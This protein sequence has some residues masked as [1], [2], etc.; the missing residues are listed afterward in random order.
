MMPSVTIINKRLVITF[1]TVLSESPFGW[2][3]TGEVGTIIN[4][5]VSSCY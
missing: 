5:V 1:A 2:V 3:M 4:G